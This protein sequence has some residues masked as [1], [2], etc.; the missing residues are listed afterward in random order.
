MLDCERGRH[1]SFCDWLVNFTS[2][3]RHC[4]I[5]PLRLTKFMAG[6]P[7]PK[8]QQSIHFPPQRLKEME[9][10]KQKKVTRITDLNSKNN[11]PLVLLAGNFSFLLFSRR[12][13]I[14]IKNT[15]SKDADNLENYEEFWNV[16]KDEDSRRDDNSFVPESH[17]LSSEFEDDHQ[18]KVEEE[19]VFVKTEHLLDLDDDYS[20]TGHD[21]DS[22]LNQESSFHGGNGFDEPHNEDHQLESGSNSFNNNHD[23][24]S[25]EIEKDIP[26]EQSKPSKAKR[27]RSRKE[28]EEPSF[29]E[30]R[31]SRRMTMKPLQ[32][33][34]NEKVVYGR[35]SMENFPV[36]TIKRVI[37]QPPSPIPTQK[38][39]SR[40]STLQKTLAAHGYREEPKATISVLDSETGNEVEK[41]SGFA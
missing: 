4:N 40:K 41:S 20:Q 33:W 26:S 13:G 27:P 18:L 5:L 15:I 30:Y 19:N 8:N 21:N 24:G 29:E 39:K 22:N 14:Q 28:K 9:H 23:E 32:F 16:L 31:K 34:K 37:T 7:C 35:P 6:Y 11:L 36:P 2:I 1:K 38:H 3:F 10:S 12:T 25:V 17:K